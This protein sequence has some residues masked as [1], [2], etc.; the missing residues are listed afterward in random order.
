M[1][2]CMCKRTGDAPFCDGSHNNLPG[3]YREDDPDSE[4]NRRVVLVSRDA[5]GVARLDGRCYV[6]TPFHARATA[7][8][9]G[10]GC[11]AVASTLGAEHQSQQVY[12]QAHGASPILSFGDA[13]AILFVSHGAGVV[14]IGGRSFD[15]EAKSGVY[16]RPREPVQWTPHPPGPMRVY[17]SA[18]PAVD[19]PARVT[20]MPHTFDASCPTR[21]VALD[22]SQRHAMAVRYF[23]MLVDRAVGSTHITQFIGHIPPS[24]ADP[25]RHLYEE[26]LIVLSGRGVMWTETRKAAVA[27]GDV[28]FF[29]RKQLHSLQCTAAE[30]MEVVG[31]IYP[32]NN[33]SVNY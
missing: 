29:P 32:G 30:G 26:A 15:V 18:G 12:E 19:V 16:V 8:D 11:V 5:D 27:P 20:T 6:F 23:Q 17:V 24:K 10:R 14:T 21:V 33:P 28:I 3:A 2:F 31:V 7:H 25:H 22:P 4:A 1:L 9:G 13:H